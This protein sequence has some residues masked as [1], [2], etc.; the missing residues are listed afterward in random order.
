MRAKAKGKKM[1]EK[2]QG[3]DEKSQTELQKQKKVGGAKSGKVGFDYIQNGKNA[4][5]TKSAKGRWHGTDKR[6]NGERKNDKRGGQ[7]L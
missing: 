3:K 4:L 6:G 7:W 1:T 5:L 2:E